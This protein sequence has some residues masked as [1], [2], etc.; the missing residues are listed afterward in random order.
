MSD[1][2]RTPFAVA[3][4]VLWAAVTSAPL[5]EADPMRR[6]HHPPGGLVAK[7]A[8]RLGLDPGARDAVHAIV[9]RSGERDEALREELEAAKL[10]MRALMKESHQP[11]AATV[12]SQAEAIGAV[13]I[14]IH[15]NRLGA[16]LQI[17]ALLTPEQRTELMRIRDEKH[18]HG[19]KR[20]RHR[21][22]GCDPDLGEYCA[23]V[24]PGPDSLTCLLAHWDELSERCRDT[25]D[26]TRRD[27]E[28]G[29]H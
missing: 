14:A 8:E 12:M 19:W 21:R 10:Q 24:E 7:Y 16:I 27:A 17:R 6:G 26:P 15:K 4:A 29:P 25:F 3:I 13:E 11:D 9:Q 2:R 18:P 28:R 5:A 22:G 1:V 20:G 23:E